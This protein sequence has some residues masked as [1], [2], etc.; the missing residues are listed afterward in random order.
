MRDDS[1]PTSLTEAR[2]RRLLEVEPILRRRT[3]KD[4]KKFLDV[5]RWPD[6]RRDETLI[7]VVAPQMS[8][9]LAGCHEDPVQFFRDRSRMLMIF[10]AL[11]AGGV[12][13]LMEKFNQSATGELLGSA[14]RNMREKGFGIPA[15]AEEMLSQTTGN[16]HIQVRQWQS[17][18]PEEEESVKNC[19][20][21]IEDMLSRRRTRPPGH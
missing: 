7:D 15:A 2:I 3:K 1:T 19:M 21:E 5:P 10:M 20:K 4:A 18:Q 9:Y 11:K 6:I 14:V 12:R 8:G 13:T 17:V 16:A